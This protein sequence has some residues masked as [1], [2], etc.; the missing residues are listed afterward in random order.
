ME[1]RLINK[2]GAKSIDCHA[3]QATQ[4]GK[5]GLG[6]LKIPS[7]W[8]IPFVAIDSLVFHDYINTKNRTKKQRLIQNV[9]IH[10]REALK[11]QGI[12][13]NNAI[14][15]RS[16]GVEEGMTERGL[17][18]SKK[19]KISEI[20]QTLKELF[21]GI[22][23][24]HKSPPD[25][26]YI[27]QEYFDGKV[28]GHLSN[29][30]RFT[31]VKRDWIY[32]Y[33]YKSTKN[34][35]E[36][37]SG[38]ISLRNWRKP[39][40]ATGK[41]TLYCDKRRDIQN[42]LQTV[43]EYYTRQ[44]RIVHFEFV[45]DGT[46]IYIVQAD[47][48]DEK[49][50]LGEDP[51]AIDI[52][53]KGAE[54]LSNLQVLRLITAADR[55]FSKVANTLI[56]S[57]AGLKTVPLYILDDKSI[58]AKIRRK[59]L[60]AALKSDLKELS[61]FSIVIRTDI[62][63]DNQVDKQLLHRSNELRSFDELVKWLFSQEELLASEKDIA[64]LF[65]VF[66]PARCSAFVKASPTGRI[67]EIEA[68]WGLPEG[69]YYNAHDKIF[70]DTKLIEANL[71]STDVAEIKKIKY[72]YKETFIAPNSSGAWVGK[73]TKPP[74]DWKL[75]VNE[76]SI[77]QIAIESRKIAN[78][79]QKQISVM[80]FIGIDEKYYGTANLAWYHEPYTKRSYTELNYK[81][82]HFHENVLVVSDADS[83]Q[84]FVNDLSVK[85]VRVHPVEDELLRDR[86]FLEKVGKTAVEKDAI[87]ILEGTAL[88]HP[89]Y[90]LCRTGAKVII[91]DAQDEF[92]EEENYNKLVRDK[93][94]EI[95]EQNGEDICCYVL[96]KGP[97]LRALLE[98][99]VEEA[100][101]IV[102]APNEGAL[103]EELCDEYEVLC[104]IE[105]LFHNG[106]T[107]EKMHFKSIQINSTD[108][109]QCEMEKT[110]DIFLWEGAHC[111][112]YSL[113][114]LGN[115]MCAVSYDA[116]QL[117]VELHFSREALQRPTAE[118]KAQPTILEKSLAKDIAS[119]SFSLTSIPET[120]ELINSVKNLKS[121]VSQAGQSIPNWN[122]KIFENKVQQKR[123]KR[124]SFEMG[125]LLKSTKLATDSDDEQE[126]HTLELPPPEFKK[127][128]ILEYQPVKNVD[129][130][131]RKGGELLIR[132]SLP[133]CFNE[134]Q[135]LLDSISTQKYIG[136]GKELM[137]ALSRNGH[138]LKLK[139]YLDSG[140]QKYEQMALDPIFL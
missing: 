74:Y 51:T 50:P 17:Y 16:S 90:Q 108:N 139:I 75:C 96:E 5:K 78:L 91:S 71:L 112:T 10:L 118:K 76:Q 57:Q 13:A 21:D 53:V 24:E 103:A 110:I 7:P 122:P 15:I 86:K 114:T 60:P 30:R 40:A 47:Y 39:F 27:V 134:Y 48:D 102:N 37:E 64:F 73:R 77:K 93:I 107:V 119:L 97:F 54:S 132:L 116:T 49:E 9:A 106:A 70:V 87:I 123:N 63:T 18:D 61:K 31:R 82:K 128:F 89:L 29:E 32:E 99:T 46:R 137:L 129:Y 35:T 83:Y 45:W 84:K 98:K 58:L 92:G 12:S 34:T 23:R 8:S 65:H 100:Y 3:A 36:I 124:G 126:Q 81:R 111:W 125:Y 26:A 94:P 80:W 104:A 59:N 42:A 68:L 2:C 4:I 67:V 19:C 25:V 85:Q 44:K 121:L 127:M 130:L 109:F 11:Q 135:L 131:D 101:E 1:I 41:E 115:I 52:S 136:T 66:V 117:Q 55:R 56:Y 120:Q 88:A 133:I 22:I 6:L 43:A 113:P 95:I 33:S 138:H 14:I 72:A 62:A 79:E 140:S 105:R 38:R 20:E 69:L 28:I